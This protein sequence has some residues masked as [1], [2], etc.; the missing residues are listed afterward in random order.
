MARTRM[1]RTKPRL[2]DAGYLYSSD[3]EEF[4]PGVVCVGAAIRDQAGAVIGGISA[5]M[6]TMRASKEHL[7]LV[8][9]EV[10]AATRALSIEFGASANERPKAQPK[11]AS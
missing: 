6:P 3:Q 7:A 1:Q 11:A 10:M 4:L 2:I 8:R 9:D 5:S